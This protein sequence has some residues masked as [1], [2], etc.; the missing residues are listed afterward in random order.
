MPRGAH[1]GEL[2]ELILLAVLGARGEAD[3]GEIRRSLAEVAGRKVSLSTVY[4]TLLRLE[5]K[6]YANSRKGDPT[7]SRGGKAK[8]LYGVTP[9]GVEVL[10]S[11]RTVRER[12]WD[13]VDR[14]EAR[15]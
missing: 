3:G 4:V 11:A 9:E 14:S 5:E 7:P 10:E 13:G 15:A 1:L 6:G 8:R 2:E 12:M